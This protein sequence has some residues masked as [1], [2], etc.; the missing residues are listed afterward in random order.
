[1]SWLE[2]LKPAIVVAF[3]RFFFSGVASYVQ[4]L[5]SFVML[6][7]MKVLLAYDED[8]EEEEEGEKE[9]VAKKDN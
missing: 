9:A 4:P 7:E 6:S 1:M 3:D 8:T 5:C 2:H